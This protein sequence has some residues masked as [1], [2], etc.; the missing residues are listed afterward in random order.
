MSTEVHLPGL[1]QA[2]R[3]FPRKRR[4]RI[5]SCSSRSMRTMPSSP[6]MLNSTPVASRSSPR[7]TFTWRGHGVRVH[8]N[9]PVSPQSLASP[10]LV[11]LGGGDG[12]QVL[13][14][15][16]DNFLTVLQVHG[17]HASLRVGTAWSAWP[18]PN[19]GLIV[20]LKTQAQGSF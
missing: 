10:Y 6:S 17:A 4:L 3:S 20:T 18:A 11:V 12:L 7:I 16:A 14:G 15:D 13:T 5:L 2:S 9:S 19:I 1:S 8:V